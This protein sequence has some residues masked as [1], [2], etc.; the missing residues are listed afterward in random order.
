MKIRLYLKDPDGMSNSVQ[1]AI[2]DEVE[3]IGLNSQNEVDSVMELRE[4]EVWESLE[5]WIEFK[6]YVMIEIDTDAMTARVLPCTE[7]RF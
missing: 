3:G 6:E 4:E 7:G 1:E 2:R 5:K